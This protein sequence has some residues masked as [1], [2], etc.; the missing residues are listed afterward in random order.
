MNVNGTELEQLIH[1][2]RHI[3]NVVPERLA[4]RIWALNPEYLLL[5]QWV[6]ILAP[7]HIR[8]PERQKPIQY[9]K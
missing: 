6:P 9:C 1:T 8:I 7:T 3:S 4:E 2:H 5:S